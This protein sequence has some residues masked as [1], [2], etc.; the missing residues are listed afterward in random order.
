MGIVSIAKTNSGIKEG[1]AIAL[2]LIGGLREFINHNDRIMLKPNLNGTEG[3]TNIEFTETLIRLL[4]DFKVKKIAIAESTF[5][6]QNITDMCFNKTGY[7]GLARK[8]NIELINLNKSEAIEVKVKKPL[9]LDSIKIAKEVFDFDKIINLP[10]MKVHYATGVTLALK[11]LKGLLVREQ[12]RCFHE[13]GLE[14]AIVDLNNTIAPH[15]NIIDCIS[16]M[17]KMGPRDGDVVELNLL[18]AGKERAE[19]DYVGCQIMGFELDEIKH[20]QYYVQTNGIDL[21][22]LEIVGE[23]IDDVKHPFKKAKMDDIIP[24]YVIVHNRNACSA[25]MNALLLSFQLFDRE[26]PKKTDIYLGSKID[27]NDTAAGFKIAFGNCCPR[28]ENFDLKIK[29]CPP[30][31]FDLKNIFTERK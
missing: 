21:D 22:K 9:A 7:T 28:G 13:I 27:K 11:N 3:V 30:Y 18:I 23:T 10:V 1:L 16:C 25:C 4:S 26:F 8:Y 17:E 14:K 20:L 2:D 31:P 19:V 6:N 12:K 29:G 24:E 15:L 5:G